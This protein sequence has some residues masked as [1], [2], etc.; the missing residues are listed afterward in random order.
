[1]AVMYLSDRVLVGTQLDERR[2][3]TLEA[4]LR[5]RH[6]D[7]GLFLRGSHRVT[8][9]VSALLPARASPCA[10]SALQDTPNPAD[11]GREE[12]AVR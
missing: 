1:M 10:P 6:G 5:F 3:V 11:S 7:V 9:I 8:N 4:T 12:G 2:I